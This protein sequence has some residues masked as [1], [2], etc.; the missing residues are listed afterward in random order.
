M[1]YG[2]KTHGFAWARHHH[3]KV[4]EAESHYLTYL[5]DKPAKF[6]LQFFRLLIRSATVGLMF[7]WS[8]LCGRVQ[9]FDRADRPDPEGAKPGDLPFERRQFDLE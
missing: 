3:D 7:I 5:S 9:V 4:L 1:S 6:K 8:R 2:T